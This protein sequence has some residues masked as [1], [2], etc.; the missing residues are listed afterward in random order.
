MLYM[1][2]KCTTGTPCLRKINFQNKVFNYFL[3]LIHA[4]AM[5][6]LFYLNKIAI[7]TNVFHVIDHY[8]KYV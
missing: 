1:Y 8:E 2:V 6:Y 7:V 5:L 4:I 3:F